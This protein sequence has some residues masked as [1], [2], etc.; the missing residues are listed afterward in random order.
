MEVS[1]NGGE[2]LADVLERVAI[3]AGG[4]GRVRIRGLDDAGRAAEGRAVAR[5]LQ[6]EHFLIAGL[7]LVP[8]RLF[9]RIEIGLGNDA[10][11]DKLLLV[12]FPESRAVGDFLRDDGLGERRLVGLVVALA[13]VTIHV[14][15]DVAA[16]FLAE[17]QGEERGPIELHRL[18]AVHVEDRCLDHFRDVGRVGG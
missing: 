8:D 10:L 3:D 11:G 1:R 2:H 5:L 18:L 7:Q 15:D 9:Q 14:D 16:E 4:N 6:L 12:D 17:L 13:T